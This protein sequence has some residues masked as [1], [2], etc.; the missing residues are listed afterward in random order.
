MLVE[1]RHETYG[2][3]LCSTESKKDLL[4]KLNDISMLFL[5]SQKVLN[6]GEQAVAKISRVNLYIWLLYEITNCTKTENSEDISLL[7]SDTIYSDICYVTKCCCRFL[8]FSSDNYP[9]KLKPA[10]LAASLLRLIDFHANNQ[11]KVKLPPNLV[12]LIAESIDHESQF[13]QLVDAT[14]HFQH[15]SDLYLNGQYF[16]SQLGDVPST[17]DDSLTD[18]TKTKQEYALASLFHDIGMLKCHHAYLT[19]STWKDKYTVEENVEYLKQLKFISST[20][21]TNIHTYEYVEY[22]QH[23]FSSAL[24]LH[25]EAK[26]HNLHLPGEQSPQLTIE[27]PVIPAVR[28]ILFHSMCYLPDKNDDDSLEKDLSAMTLALF[29]SI[30]TWRPSTTSI[31]NSQNIMSYGFGTAIEADLARFDDKRLE[32]VENKI[33]LLRETTIG[34]SLQYLLKLMQGFGR[35]S[36][37]HYLNDDPVIL[38]EVDD[39]AILL[40]ELKRLSELLFHEVCDGIKDWINLQFEFCTF[41]TEKANVE[42]A[43]TDDEKNGEEGSFTDIPTINLQRL[44]KF[45]HS[46]SPEEIEKQV[47]II[48]SNN[49][50]LG[51]FDVV[52]FMEIPRVRDF[53]KHRSRFH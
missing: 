29:D 22:Q 21:A 35:L 24:M 47:I 52:K 16:L 15:V 20:E 8:L 41:L 48:P 42:H 32:V 50:I 43:N 26:R 39:K 49:K 25:H 2:K 7:P 38:L 10:R 17:P 9:F 44:K 27:S 34:N 18:L 1:H 31:G 13:G 46:I 5:T 11:L 33:F 3:K 4:K 53:L 28:S 6:N 12:Q 14:Q 36:F 23:A 40:K 45:S 37:N 51:N 19:T 30:Y